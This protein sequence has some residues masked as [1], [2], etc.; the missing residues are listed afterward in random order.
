VSSNV[1]AAQVH[2]IDTSVQ[3]KARLVSALETIIL[4]SAF[5]CSFQFQAAPLHIGY[6]YSYEPGVALVA[7]RQALTMRNV[8]SLPLS[9][10]MHPTVPFTIDRPDWLLEPQEAVTVN[11]GFDAGYRADNQSHVVGTDEQRTHRTP[12][13]KLTLNSLHMDAGLFIALHKSC[14]P[15]HPP[16]LLL[17]VAI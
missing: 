1:R 11:V 2:S 15:Q 9:F 7:Q 13:H 12:H 8:S 16:R 10:S 4:F 17:N 14:S 3:S 5:N 6:E